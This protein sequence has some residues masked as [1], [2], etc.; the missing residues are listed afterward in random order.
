MKKR[1]AQSQII[2]TVLIILLVL[3]AIGVVWNVINVVIKEGSSEVNIAQF[4]INANIKS[5]IIE[6]STSGANTTIKLQRG[7]GKGEV[8]GVQLVFEDATK[9]SHIYKNTTL[10][11]KELETETFFITNTT[12]GITSTTMSTFEKIEIYF[13]ILD[14]DGNEHFT[15]PLDSKKM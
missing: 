6:N 3:A 2:T 11:I 12:L 9:Y 15:R 10:S 1:K 7:S 4:T 14:E 5:V 8:N 13:I